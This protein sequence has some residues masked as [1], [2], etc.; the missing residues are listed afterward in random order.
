M[1]EDK[2]IESLLESCEDFKETID[3]LT[4]ENAFLT[5]TIEKNNLGKI[6]AERQALLQTAAEAEKIQREYDDK[7]IEINRR[8]QDVKSKQTDI[9]SYIDAE[10]KKKIRDVKKSYALQKEADDKEVKELETKNKMLGRKC[11]IYQLLAIAGI[12]FGLIELLL[13]RI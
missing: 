12:A 2:A 3:R 4:E 10:T 13:I 9:A 1:T 7:L 5:D 6:A 8:L 11:R